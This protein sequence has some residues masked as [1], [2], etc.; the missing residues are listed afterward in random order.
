M[1]MV[2]RAR[3]GVG[4]TVSERAKVD[5]AEGEAAADGLDLLALLALCDGET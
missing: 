1:D 2:A 5:D 3:R 4:E